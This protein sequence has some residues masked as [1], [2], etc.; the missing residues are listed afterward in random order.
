V[1][2]QQGDDLS[3]KAPSTPLRVGR[4]L[5]AEPDGKADGAGDGGILH[6]GNG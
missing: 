6:A 3:V 4:D 2:A 5:L 1:P